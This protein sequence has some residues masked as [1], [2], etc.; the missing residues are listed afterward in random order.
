MSLFDCIK[1]WPENPGLTLVIELKYGKPRPKREYLESLPTTVLESVHK[2]FF[3]NF[4]VPNVSREVMIDHVRVMLGGF[5]HEGTAE[6][7]Q[8][9]L[10]KYHSLLGHV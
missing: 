10:F 1:V 9:E 6:F 3:P 2:E 4:P 7:V 8:Q 5:R